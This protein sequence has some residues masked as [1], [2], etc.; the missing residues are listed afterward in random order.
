M[1]REEG[2]QQ[3]RDAKRNTEASTGGRHAQATSIARAFPTG[4][5]R[6]WLGE[7]DAFKAML[8][9]FKDKKINQ[10]MTQERTHPTTAHRRG[11]AN[12]HDEFAVLQFQ[13]DDRAR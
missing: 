2:A 3:T 12:D 11:E 13:G 7:F 1:R 5:E 10:D 4:G 9:D 6:L 8:D